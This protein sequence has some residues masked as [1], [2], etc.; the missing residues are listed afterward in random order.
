MS[1][2]M[3]IPINVMYGILCL[4]FGLAVISVVFKLQETIKIKT[5]EEKGGNN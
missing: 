2:A 5:T 3:M 4:G 1:P